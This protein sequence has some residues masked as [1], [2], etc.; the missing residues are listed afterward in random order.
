MKN[1][2]F[3]IGSYLSNDVKAAS[4]LFRITCDHQGGNAVVEDLGLQSM[5]LT[6]FSV[7]GSELY[8]ANKI[9]SYE[10]KYDGAISAYRMEGEGFLL[11]NERSA[12][13]AGTVYTCISMDGRF[14]YVCNYMDG[15]VVGYRLVGDGVGVPVWMERL[16][17]SSVNRERQESPHPHA[18][19]ASPCGRYFAVADLGSDKVLLFEC[20]GDNGVL[21]CNQNLTIESAAGSGPRHVRFHPAYGHI[22][23]VT[24]EMGAFIAAYK[25]DGQA[26]T[27]VGNY[28]FPNAGQAGV[29]GA[30]IQFHPSGR[31]LYASSRGDNLIHQYS[32][33]GSSGALVLVQSVF[34]GG[35]CP[36]SFD[37]S[38]NGRHLLVCNQHSDCVTLFDIHEETGGVSFRSEFQIS[39][40]IMTCRM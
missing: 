7:K 40:P 28:L 25:L 26:C 6:H 11:T 3:L 21:S 33:E 4:S 22:F 14:I 23:Y 30:E 29:S 18:I 27:E 17:G 9:F 38:S 20:A 39:H 24:H 5:E 31:Y 10:G 34:C 2:V 32:V 16:H 37:V 19:E 8:V 1:S 35:N 15:N 12:M 36:V 13:G